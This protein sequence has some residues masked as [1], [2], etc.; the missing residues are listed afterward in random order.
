[1]EGKRNG[2][3]ARKVE[4]EEGKN[5]GRID[6]RKKKKKKKI[7]RESQRRRRVIIPTHTG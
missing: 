3:I 2:E 7:N 1:M 6:V 4:D 5:G